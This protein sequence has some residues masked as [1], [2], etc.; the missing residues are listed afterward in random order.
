MKLADHEAERSYLGGIFLDPSLLERAMV[1]PVDFHATAHATIVEVMQA[2]RSRG[3]P[4]DTITVRMELVR[5]GDL[6]RVGDDLLLAITNAVIPQETTIECATRIREL[7]SLRRA[8]EYALTA[9]AR[10]EEQDRAGAQSALDRAALEQGRGTRVGSAADAVATVEREIRSRAEL[11]RPPYVATG[12]GALDAAIAGCEYGDLWI[13]GGDTSV[14]KS[15]TALLMA[16][17]MARN[18]HRPGIISFEDAEPRMGRRVLSMLSGVPPVAL[19][20]G[21]LSPWQWEAIEQATVRVRGANVTIAY[22]VGET[23]RELADATGMLR[24]EYGCDVIFADYAQAIRVP[25]VEERIAMREVCAIFKRE[26][27]RGEAPAL[28]IL[29][30]QLRRRDDT[31]IMPTRRDLFESSYLEQKAD[32]II[33]LWRDESATVQGVLDKAK[34]DSPGVLFALERDARSGLLREAA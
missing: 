5:R 30:S 11:P 13:L 7:A 12:I 16:F 25:G 3:S 15:S 31:S 1:K 34:D 32:G 4:V 29:L 27:V 22:R 14:G 6:A 26:C 18:G 19:R 10:Y 33:L 8:R 23:I 21:D 2:L 24:R 20:R 9:A 28:G 17:A